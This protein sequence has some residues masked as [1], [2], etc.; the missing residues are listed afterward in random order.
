LCRPIFGH[1]NPHQIVPNPCHF[2]TDFAR[3]VSLMFF[4]GGMADKCTLCW[5]PYGRLCFSAR[6][7]TR[8]TEIMEARIW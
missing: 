6:Y 5:R 2:L 8:L 1:I 3:R 7:T 4:T